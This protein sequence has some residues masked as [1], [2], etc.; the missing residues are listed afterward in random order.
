MWQWILYYG[1]E[2]DYNLHIM[3]TVYVDFNYQP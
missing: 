1:N 3:P 2:I